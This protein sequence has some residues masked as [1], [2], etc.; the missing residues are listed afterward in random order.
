M[1]SQC[2]Y[3]HC[4]GVPGC[5]YGPVD[6]V[7]RHVRVFE[8]Y[9]IQKEQWCRSGSW[10]S[11][12]DSKIPSEEN[13]STG[14]FPERWLLVNE[15][16]EIEV[17]LELF[18]ATLF[19]FVSAWSSYCNFECVQTQSEQEM[20]DFFA[21]R[22]DLKRGKFLPFWTW[23]TGS[24]VLDAKNFECLPFRSSLLLPMWY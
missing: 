16:V 2:Q 5:K 10:C 12:F 7:L 17:V 15:L 13:W 23:S 8:K 6:A 11:I 24:L 14:R 9:A 19:Y 1:K 22:S 18:H 3:S 4:R 21:T 20:I